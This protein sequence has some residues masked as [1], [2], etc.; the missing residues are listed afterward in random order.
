MSD[1]TREE[2]RDFKQDVKDD[3]NNLGDT[4]R[5]QIRDNK[6]EAKDDIKAVWSA[7]NGMIF[8]VAAVVT[9]CTTV[10]TATVM[11]IAELVKAAPK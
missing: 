8:K 9:I 4:V 11:I 2:F 5:E 10:V 1:I 6:Q 3:I 7:I